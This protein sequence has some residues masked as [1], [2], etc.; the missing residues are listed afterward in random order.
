LLLILIKALILVVDMLSSTE[1]AIAAAVAPDVIK[2]AAP[3]ILN[4]FFIKTSL[5]SLGFII[6]F[7]F[8]S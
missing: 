3:Q 2:I 6:L 4:V 7:N 5:L 8:L 1:F